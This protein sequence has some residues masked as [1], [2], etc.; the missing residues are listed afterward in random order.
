MINIP[1]TSNYINGWFDIGCWAQI[2]C[3]KFAPVWITYGGTGLG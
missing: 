1:Y 2:M 3:R